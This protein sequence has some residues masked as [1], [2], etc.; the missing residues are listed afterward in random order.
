MKKI[1][2]IVGARPQFVKLGPLS[3]RVRQHFVEV[4]VHTGQHYDYSMS[5]SFFDDLGIP[6]PDHFL[7]VGSGSHGS[8]TGEMLSRI[9]NVLEI[10]KPQLVIVFGD[11]N[12]TLA[13]ALAAVKLQIPIIHIEAG[14]R[15]FNRAMPEEINRVVADHVSDHLFVPTTTGMKNLSDEGLENKAILTGDIMVESVKEASSLS[16]VRSSVLSDFGLSGAPY[17]L[18]TLHRPYNVDNPN[19]LKKILAELESLSFPVVFPIHP[20]THKLIL[21]HKIPIP[22]N[23]MVKNPQGYFDFMMLLNNAK[24]VITDSGGIQKEACILHRPCI[25]LRTETEWMET[26]EAGVNLLLNPELRIDG[27]EIESFMPS[28][29]N[30]IPLFGENVGQKMLDEI[31]RILN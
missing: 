3:K 30:T 14:L 11:T 17:Y 29:N 31:I 26:V 1:V 6:N 15:S 24:A 9:E 19:K 18:L 13:G 21:H 25:T 28:F 2:S 22:H 10:E 20:R 23:F 16:L 8:Q 27:A 7:E 5:Q 12:S 4:V